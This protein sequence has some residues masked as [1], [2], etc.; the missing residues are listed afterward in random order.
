[1]ARRRR[2]A[3]PDLRPAAI[4]RDALDI[5]PPGLD[6]SFAGKDGRYFYPERYPTSYLSA[7]TIFGTPARV[8]VGRSVPKSA[9]PNLLKLYSPTPTLAFNVPRETLV[10][11]RRKVRRKVIFATRKTGKGS[12]SPRKLSRYSG[13]SCK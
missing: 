9:K 6:I 12:R 1:M 3:S 10:C 8:T 2:S 7:R 13:V 11:V 5:A 4:E